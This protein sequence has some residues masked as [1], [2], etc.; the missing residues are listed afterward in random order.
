MIEYSV[1][2]KAKKIWDKIIVNVP[3]DLLTEFDRVSATQYYS[4]SEA[5]K[6]S[7]RQFIIEQTPEDYLSPN[8][9]TEMKEQGADAFEAMTKGIVRSASDPEVQKM[10]A[11]QQ[12]HQLEVN[13]QLQQ[14]Q[15]KQQIQKSHVPPQNPKIVRGTLDKLTPR[16]ARRKQKSR[17]R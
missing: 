3:K 2:K 10:N 9:R 11:Q 14:E 15:L 13:Q 12:M 7:M 16:S 8:M 6:E 5:I 17:K 4:R 1:K